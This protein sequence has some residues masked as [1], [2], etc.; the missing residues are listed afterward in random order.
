MLFAE[1]C[2]K[3]FS[4]KHS[5]LKQVFYLH[6]KRDAHYDYDGREMAAIS[7]LDHYFLIEYLSEITKDVTY[8]NFKF[9]SLNLTFIWDLPEYE[10]ILDKALEIIISKAPIFSN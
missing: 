7:Y 1:K 6:K 8:I 2:S 9:D 4:E 10:D 5:L 3:Y